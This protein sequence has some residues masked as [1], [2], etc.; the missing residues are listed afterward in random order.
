MQSPPQLIHTHS[1]LLVHLTIY[2]TTTL[3]SA[4]S[5]QSSQFT[6]SL[7]S[8]LISYLIQNLTN[9]TKHFISPL[10]PSHS[11][12]AAHPHHTYYHHSHHYHQTSATLYKISQTSCIPHHTSFNNLPLPQHCPSLPHIPSPH[13]S[14]SPNIHYLIQNLTNLLHHH[15]F[16]P[17]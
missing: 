11:H 4:S 10:T 15:Y 9:L 2:F 5:I 12:N 13:S 8:L 6:P 14:L 17:L 3:S 1:H 16:L 7:P